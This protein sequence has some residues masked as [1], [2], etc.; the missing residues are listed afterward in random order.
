M[1]LEK[2]VVTSMWTI[3][4]YM[5]IPT[6]LKYCKFLLLYTTVKYF[7]ILLQIFVISQSYVHVFIYESSMSM[8]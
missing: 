6:L 2:H 7:C 1:N 5:L 4:M 8:T 3:Y